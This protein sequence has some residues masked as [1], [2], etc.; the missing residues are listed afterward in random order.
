ML[1]QRSELEAL[2]PHAGSMCLL[3]GVEAWDDRSI[4]CLSR[5]HRLEDNPLRSRGILHSLHLAEYGAQAM[6]VHGG[7]LARQEG[8][9]AAPGFLAVL[10]GIR[11]HRPRIDDI[12]EEL[13]I[14]ARQLMAGDKGWTYGF[15]ISHAREPLASGRAT[16][17]LLEGGG[18]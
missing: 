5:S 7:L 17:M 14:I 4:T 3:D 8:A 10:R 13:M 6:A 11:L 1:L 2:I 16:V 9:R 18:T 15:E 12:E